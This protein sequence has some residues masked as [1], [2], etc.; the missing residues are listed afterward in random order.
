MP[1]T[2]T[3][4]RAVLP[5]DATY[6]SK[7]PSRDRAVPDV[8]PDPFRAIEVTIEGRPPTPNYR[9]GNWQVDRRL[10]DQW[11]H[12]AKMAALDAVNR[13]PRRHGGVPWRSLNRCM[14]DVRFIVPTKA[15]RDWDNLIATIKPLLDGIV[16]AGVIDD[17][18]D[19]C[20]EA[21]HF[22][23]EHEPKRQATTFSFH[24]ILDDLPR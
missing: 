12:V 15:A 20:I 6:L 24:E 2:S 4:G 17:D 7:R 8:E 3:R 10:R 5:D 21:V 11:K 23:I 19:R 9:P 14:L 13:W 1:G 22:V 16:A 18:S